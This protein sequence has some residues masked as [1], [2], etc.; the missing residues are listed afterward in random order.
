MSI[1]STKFL[2]FSKIICQREDIGL[3]FLW[4]CQHF[5]WQAFVQVD[6]RTLS[7]WTKFDFI[8][9]DPQ[10]GVVLYEQFQ[11]LCG[12]AGKHDE[13]YVW[14][15]ELLHVGVEQ[16]KQLKLRETAMKKLR[17]N[18]RC[19]SR[20]CRNRGQFI[21]F[22]TLMNFFAFISFYFFNCKLQ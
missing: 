15:S 1:I 10:H 18:I 6:G 14:Q 11:C 13:C 16:G 22:F 21:F 12:M 2:Y 20:K 9:A 3:T 17:K 7:R 19:N 8:R 5:I 4:I